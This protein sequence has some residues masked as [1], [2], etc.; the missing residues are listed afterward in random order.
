MSAKLIGN[1]LLFFGVLAIVLSTLNAYQVL[2]HQTK[3]ITYFKPEDTTF[4]IKGLVENLS[5]ELNNPS[6]KNTAVQK[7]ILSPTLI[8]DSVNL[9]IHLFLLGIISGA[10]FKL[11]SIGAMLV[12]SIEV[13]LIQ[14]PFEKITKSA[15]NQPK[16]E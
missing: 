6:V 3:P 4:D 7:D 1:L 5:P 16:S 2:T 13:K 15:A 14:S 10:G 8:N 9:T 11:A 12:R